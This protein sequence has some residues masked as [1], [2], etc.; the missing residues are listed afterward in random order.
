MSPEIHDTMGWSIIVNNVDGLII[1]RNKFK[2]EMIE[3]MANQWNVM[4]ICLTETHL[5]ES[6]SE[7]EVHMKGYV[8]HRADR[9]EGRKKGGVAIYLNEYFAPGAKQ[10]L[11]FSNGFVEALVLHLRKMKIIVVAMYRPPMCPCHH[12][13]SAMLRIREVI[14]EC[15]SS[16]PDMIVAGDFN[17]PDVEWTNQTIYGGR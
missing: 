3:E 1:K 4:M 15:H 17:F 13:A 2:K 11:A 7:A 9:L 6:F 5:N 12:F 10:L 14:D 16:M 8:V